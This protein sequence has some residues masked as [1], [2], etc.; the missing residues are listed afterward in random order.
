MMMWGGLAGGA[1]VA[2][3]SIF[4]RSVTTASNS[5]KP[6]V[7]SEESSATPERANLET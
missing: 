3:G 4:S 7:I 2:S 1:Q 6:C 5:M